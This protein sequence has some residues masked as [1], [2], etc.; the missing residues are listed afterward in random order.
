MAVTDQTHFAFRPKLMLALLLPLALIFLPTTT[1]LVT[2][3]IPTL[4]AFVIDS[5]RRRYLTITVGGLNLVGSLYFL[6]QLWVLGQRLSDI[7]IVLANSYGWLAALSGAAFGWLLFLGMPFVVRNVAIAEAR[8]RLYSL[9]REQE[10]LVQD[11]GK[12][13]T[14]EEAATLMKE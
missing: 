12:A 1:V 5:N 14:G 4:V 9:R 10:K 6:R 13:V 2:G 7:P 8:I 3:M 11:W